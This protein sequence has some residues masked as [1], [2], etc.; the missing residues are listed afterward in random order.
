MST[1]EDLAKQDDSPITDP[2]DLGRL[3]KAAEVLQLHIE[4]GLTI[5]AACKQVGISRATYAR[6][7][8]DGIFQPLIAAY[9]GPLQLQL[10][11]KALQGI[12]D[13]L[14]YL[15]ST[16]GGNTKGATNFDRMNA[17]K[18]LWEKFAA[19]LLESGAPVPDP[20]EEEE[21][22]DNE[23]KD[24][25]KSKPDWT[26]ELKP[27]E[28]FTET[29]KITRDPDPIDVTPPGETEEEPQG[30]EPDKTDS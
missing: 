6:W 18:Y 14:D 8:R 2:Q 29:R 25:L 21:E 9:V 1:A 22:E 24:F 17:G 27:G 20:Q 15:I 7:V 13:F 12:G 26:K 4:Q 30:E 28:S 3:M 16:A 5:T 19:P 10:Q 23:A 11:S